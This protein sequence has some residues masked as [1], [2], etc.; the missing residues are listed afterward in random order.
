MVVPGKWMALRMNWGATRF[1]AASGSAIHRFIHRVGQLLSRQFPIDAAKIG[2]PSRFH[3]SQALVGRLAKGGG[4]MRG[5]NGLTAPRL[6][7]RLMAA[8]AGRS[9]PLPA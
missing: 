5:A 8:P 6:F 3:F 1:S 2:L 7:H 4:G 9:A